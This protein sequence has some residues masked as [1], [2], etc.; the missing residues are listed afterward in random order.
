MEFALIIWAITT[1]LPGLNVVAGLTVGILG[2]ISF[3]GLFFGLIESKAVVQWT[4]GLLKSAKVYLILAVAILIL[5]PN[6]KA[7]W[8]IAGAGAA[9]AVATS[10]FAQEL[11]TEAKDMLKE[12]M[13]RGTMEL[14]QQVADEAKKVQTTQEAK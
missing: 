4:L 7:S 9:Q 3:T 13:K 11:G 1:L 5:V 8:M 14:R 12:M 10:D 6:Q 2:A